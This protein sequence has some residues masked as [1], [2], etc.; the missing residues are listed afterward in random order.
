MWNVLEMTSSAR[1]LPK[2]RMSLKTYWTLKALASHS[3]F[4]FSYSQR[5]A[6]L[7]WREDVGEFR[8]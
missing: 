7:N 8:V 3:A 5:N 2:V 4:Q 1:P 6:V